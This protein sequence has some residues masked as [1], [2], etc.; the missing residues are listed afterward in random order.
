MVLLRERFEFMSRDKAQELRENCA[1]MTQGLVLRCESMVCRNSIVSCS[2]GT[3]PLYFT[4]CG[5]A[6]TLTPET[7]TDP[8]TYAT[9]FEYNGYSRSAEPGSAT[10]DGFVDAV[11]AVPRGTPHD[12][13]NAIAGNADAA[14]TNSRG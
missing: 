1:I 13:W 4:R 12:R 6:V 8:R 5:T 11:D 7:Y 2:V 9:S 3:K 10:A 14:E